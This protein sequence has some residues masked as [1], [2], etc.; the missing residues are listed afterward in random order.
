MALKQSK[1]VSPSILKN[2]AVS[3]NKQDSGVPWLGGVPIHWR[4]LSIRRICQVKRGASPRPIESPHYFHHD[5]EY[6]WVR[7]GDVSA[8]NKYLISTE[9]RLSEIGKSKSVPLE[10]GAL[11]LSIAGTV[12]K[13]IITKIKCCI[14]DGF[15]YFEGLKENVDYLYYLF[16]TGELFKGLGK[17]GTQLN[18]NTDTISDIKIPLP[19]LS[20]QRQIAEFL[21]RETE[22]IDRLI[23]EKENLL[24]LLEEKRK[25][26]ISQAVTKGLNPNVKLR[27]SR[28]PWLGM[29]PE[30]WR[31]IRLRFLGQV[32][33]GCGFPQSKQG[34]SDGELAFY[35]VK[36]LGN[37]GHSLSMQRPDDFISLATARELGAYIFPKGTVVFAKIGA[38]M[39][40][41]RFRLLD[42]SSCID[43]NMMGFIPGSHQ[44]L[45][46][47]A[48]HL[49][50]LFQMSYLANP[51][52]V[53]SLDVRGLRDLRFPV[54]DIA[55]Q[56]AIIASIEARTGSIY[57][58]LHKCGD[59]I[60]LLRERRAALISAAVTGRLD[61]RGTAE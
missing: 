28:I 15:V 53:P 19:P 32:K 21:D 25:A 44:Y 48:A 35:K 54:P 13:P 26:V 30:H 58:I 33:G 40:L 12:G 9:Q 43:N 41:N 38:A 4:V 56:Q 20:E 2:G 27:D 11:F 39:M 50:G 51:G 60:T 8:S 29:I 24:G 55:E 52:A 59:I 47:Y 49:L 37:G 1:G 10:P 3:L 23:A 42:R 34:R 16:C 17:L 7:I 46:E 31:L 5:G 36:H 57:S 61:V 14:H 18:L 22:K 45:S 6:A